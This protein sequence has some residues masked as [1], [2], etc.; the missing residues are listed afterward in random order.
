MKR[1]NRWLEDHPVG[2]GLLFFATCACVEAVLAFGG[3]PP[4]GPAWILGATALSLA[5]G[6]GSYYNGKRHSADVVISQRESSSGVPLLYL[7]ITWAAFILLAGGGMVFLFFQT[8]SGEFLAPGLCLAVAGCLI[9]GLLVYWCCRSL[10][11]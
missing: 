7:V 4:R 9:G 3:T 8:Q 6:W 5:L 10:R 11:G 2:T 1:V